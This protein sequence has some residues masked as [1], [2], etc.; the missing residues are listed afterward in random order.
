MARFDGCDAWA[1]P[2]SLHD[3]SSN[4]KS[5]P[6]CCKNQILLNQDG[7]LVQTLREFGR[8]QSH[9]RK[10]VVH[11]TFRNSRPSLCGSWQPFLGCSLVVCCLVCFRQQGGTSGGTTVDG[12]AWACCYLRKDL[13][14][15]PA[16]LMFRF[17]TAC[18]MATSGWMDEHK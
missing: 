5:S 18:C 6:K 9:I 15:I 17:A 11:E 7:V 12:I 4:Q 14:L 16:W 10:Y 13:L 2:E 8:K 1:F 3:K